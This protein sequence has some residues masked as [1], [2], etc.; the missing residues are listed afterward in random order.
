MLDPDLPLDPLH[1]PLA[2]DLAAVVVGA[3]AGAGVAVKARFDVVGGLMLAVAM[4]L[5]GGILRDLLLGLTPVA[6]TNQAYL[7][8]V[9]AA[10]VVGLV[11]AGLV[12]RVGRVVLTLDALALGLF[13]VVGVE[14]TLLVGQ[15]ASSAVFIGVCA[16]VGGGILVDV[17]SGQPVDVLRRGPWNATAALVGASLY[18]LL[19]WG[20]VPS[21][22]TE[23]ITITV[24]TTMRLVSLRWGVRNPSSLDIAHVRS[25]LRRRREPPA[26]V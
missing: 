11:F 5:G 4:G 19:T 15:P 23:A 1:L 12:Q 22:V 10:A 18:V 2:V 17:L 20:Q 26:P 8:T 14:K 7:P 24:V 16:A 21:R 3:L 13:T 6:I 25:V 9:G